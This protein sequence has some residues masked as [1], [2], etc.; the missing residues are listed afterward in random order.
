MPQQWHWFLA[1]RYISFG[2][3]QIKLN[4]NSKAH[5]KSDKVLS[6]TGSKTH[7]QQRNREWKF[8]WLLKE[9]WI[10]AALLLRVW[11]V[12]SKVAL[13]MTYETT[14]EKKRVPA[15]RDR[16]NEDLIYKNRHNRLRSVICCCMCASVSRLHYFLTWNVYYDVLGRWFYRSRDGRSFSISWVKNRRQGWPKCRLSPVAGCYFEPW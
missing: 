9:N 7:W 10:A 6:G 15:N 14:P 4:E 1:R 5:K 2:L 8:A 13:L 11:P 16:T 3:Q 12:S